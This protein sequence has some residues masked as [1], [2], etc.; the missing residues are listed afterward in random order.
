MNVFVIRKTPVVPV[1][2]HNVVKEIPNAAR[3]HKEE[4]AIAIYQLL[5]SRNA[6][7]VGKFVLLKQVKHVAEQFVVK[8]D[9]NV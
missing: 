5:H 1:L 7:K 2:I 8:E 3:T 4:T 9:K 6:A